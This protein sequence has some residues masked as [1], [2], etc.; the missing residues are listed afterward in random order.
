MVRRNRARCVFLFS[1]FSFFLLSLF[2]LGERTALTPNR[3][4]VFRRLRVCAHREEHGRSRHGCGGG[5]RVQTRC[6]RQQRHRR[7]VTPLLSLLCARFS[8]PSPL[9]PHCWS[10]PGAMVLSATVEDG[11][12]IGMGARLLPGAVVGSNAYVDAGAVVPAGTNV[13]AGEVN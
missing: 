4:R 10:A 5:Q 6:A 1:L 13:P 8:R 2:F 7:S 3:W 9:L 11:A 12:M